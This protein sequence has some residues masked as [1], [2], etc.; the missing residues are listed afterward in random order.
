MPRCPPVMR[1]EAAPLLERI[2]VELPIVQAGMG[3]GLAGP[4]LAAAVSE[5][6]GLGTVGMLGAR[7]LGGGVAAARETTGRPVAVNLLLPFTRGAH[8]DAARRADVVVTF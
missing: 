5:A 4:E 2:G 6:G 1:P 3:G 7:P 8:W